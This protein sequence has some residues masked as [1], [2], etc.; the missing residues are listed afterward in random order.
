VAPSPVNPEAPIN[1][2]ARL[3][4]GAAILLILIV[5]GVLLVPPYAANWRLQSYVNDL[6]DDPETA[7]LPP[8]IV[9]TRVLNQAAGLGLPVRGD[10]VHV[11][12]T[13]GAVKIDVLYIVHVDLAGYTVDLH[14][15][16]AAGS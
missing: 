14:F 9:R 15:R 13:E 16:P 3:I 10:D 1:K 5:L 4:A 11:G 12:V 6:V 2:I 7:K 8:E